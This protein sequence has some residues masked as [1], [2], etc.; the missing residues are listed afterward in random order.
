MPETKTLLA[1][2]ANPQLH[3]GAQ[4]QGLRPLAFGHDLKHLLRSMD[5]QEI[6]IELTTY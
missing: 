4:A 3:R 2:F 5:M 1:L 6:A